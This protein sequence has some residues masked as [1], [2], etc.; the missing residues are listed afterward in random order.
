ML[1]V[2]SSKKK[3]NLLFHNFNRIARSV[4]LLLTLTC[5][6]R[7]LAHIKPPKLNVACLLMHGLMN[8]IKRQ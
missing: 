6:L 8:F 5:Y 2:I 1:D 7:F 3:E 4:K